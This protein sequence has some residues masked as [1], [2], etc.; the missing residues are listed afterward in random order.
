MSRREPAKLLA[1]LRHGEE[2]G[3]LRQAVD[4][5]RLL[6]WRKAWQVVRSTVTHT[7]WDWRSAPPPHDWEVGIIPGDLLARDDRPDGF[8]ARFEGA[9]L[10]VRFLAADLVRVTWRPGLDPVPCALDEREWHAPAG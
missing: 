9:D 3:K 4:G 7:Y 2:P 8:T 1:R 6:G 10:E 5:I